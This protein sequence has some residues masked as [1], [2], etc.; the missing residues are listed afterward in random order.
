[1]LLLLSSTVPPPAAV[2][3]MASAL[4]APLITPETVSVPEPFVPRRE[5]LAARMMLP[6][7]VPLALPFVDSAPRLLPLPEMVRV[8]LATVT[9]FSQIAA[10]D[11]TVVPA[12]EE[13]S[14]VAELRISVLFAV[15][16]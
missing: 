15:A 7:Q 8:S 11:P 14:A 1:M 4:A 3:L 5:L 13:P 16:L 6:A 2:A 12:A 10:P 9:L